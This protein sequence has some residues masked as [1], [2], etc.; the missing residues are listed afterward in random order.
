[1]KHLTMLALGAGLLAPA[2]LQADEALAKKH[3]CL[4]CHSV[5]KKVV[6]P[7]Y[8]DVAAKYRGDAG[9]QARLV[10]KVKNGGKGSWGNV[11]MPANS[12]KVPDADIA[13]LVR[14]VLAQ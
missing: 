8:K 11:L 6:G 5:N 10:D 7:S 4:V 12:P 1:M 9:A 14:W 3:G 2:L 13:T